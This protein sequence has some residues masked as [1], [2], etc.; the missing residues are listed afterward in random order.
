MKA[1]CMYAII[2]PVVNLQSYIQESNANIIFGCGRHCDHD[3]DDDTSSQYEDPLECVIC[4]AFCEC[5]YPKIIYTCW[6]GAV[7]ISY[8]LKRMRNATAQRTKPVELSPR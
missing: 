2:R 6:G 7:L 8:I 4:S 3:E 1:I 5:L